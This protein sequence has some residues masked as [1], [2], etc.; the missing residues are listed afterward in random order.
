MKILIS[1]IG[2]Y[3]NRVIK[4][5]A[6]IKPD[7]VY[8]C[9]M[10]HVK[11][12]KDD[13]HS[14]LYDKWETATERYAKKIIKK[15]RVFY[16]DEK[17]HILRVNIDDY[18]SAFKDLLK[19]ILSF[20]VNTEVFIDTT[21]TTHAF[22]IA[23]I[24]LSIYLKNVKCIY[25]PAQKPLFPEEYKKESIKD[26]GL[27]TRIISTPKIDFSELQTGMLKDILITMNT[28]FNGKV[29]SVTDLL[30]GLDLPNNKG[31]MIKMTKLLKKLEN[32]GCVTT[33]K[34]GRLKKVNLTVIGSSLSE[35]LKNV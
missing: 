9:T 4:G 17:I 32:Y 12:V 7:I 13:F 33:R 15:L 1:P 34:E 11:E 35:V 25:T 26:E 19:L 2:I 14:K 31:N 16:D 5:I 24:T 20:D 3:F 21:S 29:P 8:L 6:N 23:S 27:S 10:E 30:M 22:K 18:L 28:R